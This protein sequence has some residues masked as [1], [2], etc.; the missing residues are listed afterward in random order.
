MDYDRYNS[1][2]NYTD[3]LLSCFPCLNAYANNLLSPLRYHPALLNAYEK[4]TYIDILLQISRS[5]ISFIRTLLRSLTSPPIPYSTYSCD[6]IILSHLINP[7][8]LSGHFDHYF[9]PLVPELTHRGF[10]PLIVY[11]NQTCQSSPS[12]HTSSR[13]ATDQNIVFP[14]SLSTSAEI[15]SF[16]SQLYFMIT[17][18][19]VFLFSRRNIPFTLRLKILLHQISPS[20]LHAKR[21]STFVRN[22]VLYT[23]SSFVFTTYE[24]H[25]FEKSIFSVLSLLPNPPATI[26]YQHSLI[27]P[28]QHSLLRD[29]PNSSLPH[30]ILASGPYSYEVFRKIFNFKPCKPNII[31]YGTHRYTKPATNHPVPVRSKRVLLLPEGFLS[32]TLLIINLAIQTVT[33]D[34]NIHFLLRLHP[35]L[36]FTSLCSTPGFPALPQNLT[37]SSNQEINEDCATCTFAVYRGSTAILSAISNGLLPIYFNSSEPSIDPLPSGI[38]QY[39]NNPYELLNFLNSKTTS[40]TSRKITSSVSNLYSPLLL[41]SLPLP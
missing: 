19:P 32:E 29:G 5:L 11:L 37:I 8:D 28:N 17:S 38:S 6:I 36:S 39:I 16:L 13:Q 20:T 15:G 10:N 3:H 25:S 12:I 9:G 1:I 2:C 23:K 40:T 21:I 22:L 24:G 14:L 27:F 41:H 7:S 35:S 33:L 18:I 31:L 26:A 4:H 30:T 34:E